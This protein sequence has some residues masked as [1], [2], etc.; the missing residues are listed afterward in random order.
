[1]C[2][3]WPVDED[4][5]LS[6]G[7]HQRR[8]DAI[9]DLLETPGSASDIQ[10]VYVEAASEL[11]EASKSF[12]GSM[13]TEVLGGMARGAT[14][15]FLY[16]DSLGRAA[17]KGVRAIGEGLNSGQGGE[18]ADGIAFPYTIRMLAETEGRNDVVA[19]ID[20]HF[21]ESYSEIVAEI[22]ELKRRGRP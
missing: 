13:T 11:T 5:P 3:Y 10:A 1:M 7:H 9:L 4:F 21:V 22:G 17:E 16:D 14:T 19:E 20:A 6:G 12:L 2:L 8:L 18:I 15:F